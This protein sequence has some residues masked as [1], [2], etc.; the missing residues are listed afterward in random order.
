MPVNMMPEERIALVQQKVERANQ[1]IAELKSAVRA[2]LATNPYEVGTRRDPQSRKLVYYVSDARQIPSS[3]ALIAGDAIQNLR[4]ALDQLAYQ[5][6]LVGP[7]GTED[8][9]RHVYFPIEEN[10]DKFDS[11]LLNRTRGMREDAIDALRR[12]EPYRGGKGEQLWR[13]HALNNTDKHRLLLTVGSA[14]RALNIGALG[15]WHLQKLIA[16]GPLGKSWGSS[17][18][19]TRSCLRLIE[20]VP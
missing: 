19:S 16:E 8:Q 6:F 13:L 7:H 9:G 14:Y 11:N 15:T 2:F 5:L 4:T 12:L 18:K 10:K 3:F 17:P 20:C 1:H